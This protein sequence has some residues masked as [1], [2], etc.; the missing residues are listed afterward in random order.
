MANINIVLYFL[1]KMLPWNND[2]S[3]KFQSS[4]I[5]IVF[6][7]ITSNLNNYYTNMTIEKL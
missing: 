2:D 5:Q 7:N 4:A 6:I 3:I 1:E